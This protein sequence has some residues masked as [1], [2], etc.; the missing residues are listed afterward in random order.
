MKFIITKI[1]LLFY[2]VLLLPCLILGQGITSAAMNGIVTEQDGSPLPGSTVIARH[3]PSGTEF[4]TTTRDDGKYT[5][6]NLRVGGPYIVKVTYVGY[7][8]QSKEDVSLAL[9]QN[10]KIDF[11][12]IPNEVEVTG[13]TVTA[14]KSAILSQSRTGAAQ[15]VSTKQIEMMPSTSRSFQ[16]FA[17]LSPLFSGSNLQAAGRKSNYNNIQIDGTQYNDLF[18]LGSTGTP[19][20]QV[21]TT[22]IS[23]DA[24]R[25]F[26]VMVAPFDV[27]L[28]GFTGGG[29][30][31]ITRSGTNIYNASVYFYG[32][33]QS[34]VGKNPN[35]G[36]SDYPD[37]KDYQYG[38]RA[39]GPV[40][41][42]KLFFFVNAELAGN[43]QPMPQTALLSGFGGKTIDELK[44][45]ANQ[46]KAALA[47]KG[48]NTG[49]YDPVTFEQPSTKL[50]LRFDY[51]LAANQ[52]LTLHYNLIDASKDLYY[53]SRSASTLLFDTQP[54]QIKNTTN[55]IVAQL[56]SSFGNNMSNELITGFTSI[57]DKRH[58]KSADAPEI[59]IAE[60]NNTFY[61]YAG[62]DRYS[63][64]NQLDQDIFEITDNFSYYTGD[65][66][67]TIGTHNEFF[68]FRNLFVRSS[69]GY[70]QYTSIENFIND[71]PSY[72]QHVYSR[73]SDPA[74]QF[75]VAQ[76]GF[77]AQDEWLILPQLKLNLG[78]RIDIPTFPDSPAQNDSVPKYFSGYNTT[79]IPS[80]NLLFS[81]RLGLNW[82]VT[83]DRSTQVRGGIGMFTGRVP[84]VWLSNNYGN[85]G[86]T[87][88]E[89]NYS[90]TGTLPFIANPNNQYVA[91]DPRDTSSALGS[92]NLKSEIDLADPNL[93]MP[94]FGCRSAA[95]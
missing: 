5:L 50:F 93:K 34:F 48:M 43:S 89:V 92:P 85:T 69:F 44:D 12:L 84:Y 91:G 30:N 57:R 17:K 60:L 55:N 3:V 83:G 24:I 62:P 25:E 28:S 45:Y 94:Q 87:L 29:I 37:F 82:D 80:G 49:S 68:S 67:F 8:T 7:A 41:K 74:A 39:G 51:N 23:L 79:Q 4:G 21:G 32:R 71:Q 70:Y 27:K 90:G 42:D 52:Q 22:P 19:G 54:Y 31:A 33:N 59:R 47:A 73:V 76:Y 14:E 16:N 38:F 10:L 18:G 56:N 58:G 78:I 86:T 15:N 63:S 88:A 2:V 36:E 26:Q 46:M 13:V 81:P 77:Y 11:I 65:H 95:S 6:L 72:Y 61:M 40:L 1:S 64:A 20:G 53:N 35:T 75:S 66:I 9:G